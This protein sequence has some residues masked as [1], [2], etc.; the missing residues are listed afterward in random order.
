M[1]SKWYIPPFKGGK[2]QTANK[3]EINADTYN[4]EEQSNNLSS[5][6]DSPGTESKQEKKNRA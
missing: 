2:A 6:I 4:Q 3:L 5:N 1:N